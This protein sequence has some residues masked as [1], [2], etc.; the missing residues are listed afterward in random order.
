[1]TLS[2]SR[3]TVTRIGAWTVP[4]VAMAATAPAF[5]ASVDPITGL[6]EAL[7]CPGKST[8][9]EDSVVA[10][11][12]TRSLD[13]AMALAAVPIEDWAVTVNGIV[14]DVK[15]VTRLGTTIYVVTVP[16]NNS[17]NGV[18][19]LSVTYTLGT[20]TFVGQFAFDGTHPDHDIC[21]RV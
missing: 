11:F 15:R 14:W 21:G 16:R 2:P 13:D 19:T 17:A 9:Y 6:A 1:M 3:R 12:N 20:Q 8:G 5:A 18:G 4:V 7:K 10:V